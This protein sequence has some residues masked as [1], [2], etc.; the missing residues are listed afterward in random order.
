MRTKC[1]IHGKICVCTA[2][3]TVFII[4]CFMLQND[5]TCMNKLQKI[6][7][8]RKRINNYDLTSVYPEL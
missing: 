8:A 2:T 7:K 1:M 4:I 3:Y 5:K 6:T